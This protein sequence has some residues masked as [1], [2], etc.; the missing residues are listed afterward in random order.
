[1]NPNIK[2]GK[3]TC[4]LKILA[5]LESFPHDCTTF[6]CE[7]I[8]KYIIEKLET[9]ARLDLNLFEFLGFSKLSVRKAFSFLYIEIKLKF[10]N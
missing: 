1:M 9:N 3:A 2:N 10:R 4:L 6:K 5:G 8:V 7:Q